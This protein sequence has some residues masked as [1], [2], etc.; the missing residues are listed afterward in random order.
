[1]Y[2]AILFSLIINY[3]ITE[4]F[5]YETTRLNGKLNKSRTFFKL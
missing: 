2:Y 5:G 3:L 1:M 4:V